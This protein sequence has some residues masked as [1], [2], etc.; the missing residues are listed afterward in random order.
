M[1]TFYRQTIS[2]NRII[3][4]RRV[5]RKKTKQKHV[6]S[7]L[8]NFLKSTKSAYGKWSYFWGIIGPLLTLLFFYF[9][10]YPKIDI[11][12]DYSGKILN[13]FVL[14]FKIYNNNSYT[15]YNVKPVLKIFVT[16]SQNNGF[17]FYNPLQI[18]SFDTPIF[19]R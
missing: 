13:P 3:F 14:P 1:K 18:K 7:R 2:Q 12:F 16:R 5:H 8:S 4:P 6:K 9:N 19:I 15:I 10:N 11:E 17:L